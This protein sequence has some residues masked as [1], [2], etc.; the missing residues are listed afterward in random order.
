MMESAGA[1]KPAQIFDYKEYHT[2][3]TVKFIVR[4]QPEQLRRAEM[5]GLHKYFKLQSCITTTSMVGVEETW[6]KVTSLLYIF[7]GEQ[8]KTLIRS[9]KKLKAL[10]ESIIVTSKIPV[11][12]F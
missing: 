4:M 3:K 10:F 2:D 12:F 9:K 5:E 6:I 8:D 7:Q 11:F 1:D